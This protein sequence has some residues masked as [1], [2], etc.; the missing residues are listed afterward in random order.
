MKASK[1]VINVELEDVIFQSA[2]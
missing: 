2:K 1:L